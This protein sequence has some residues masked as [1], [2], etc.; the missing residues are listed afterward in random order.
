MDKSE[1][2]LS[3]PASTPSYIDPLRC[4]GRVSG[5]QVSSFPRISGQSEPISSGHWTRVQILLRCLEQRL[6]FGLYYHLDYADAMSS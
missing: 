5:A 4:I 1:M 2:S 6:V 3:Q